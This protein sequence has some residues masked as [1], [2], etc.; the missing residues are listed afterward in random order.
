MK[1]YLIFS[2]MLLNNG[3]Y[4]KVRLLGRKTIELM[5]SNH[6]TSTPNFDGKGLLSIP[7]L[8]KGFSL[9]FSVVTN[10]AETKMLNSKGTYGWGGAFGTYFQIDPKEELI[11]I[12]MI[13]RRPYSELKLREYFQNLVYQSL[14]D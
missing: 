6:T 13:Q 2:Q 3:K 4:D 11:Y 14:T 8:G 12:M 1:D 7:N 10:P 9:G 5:T